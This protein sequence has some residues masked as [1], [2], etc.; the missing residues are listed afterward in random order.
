MTDLSSPLCVNNNKASFSIVL[1]EQKITIELRASSI[2]YLSISTYNLLGSKKNVYV[3]EIC[4]IIILI[5][6][7]LW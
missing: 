4:I 5:Y 1:K 6:R 7:K 3:C 2:W